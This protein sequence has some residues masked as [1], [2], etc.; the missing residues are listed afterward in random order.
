M[1]HQP[2]APSPFE[3]PSNPFQDPSITL[4]LNSG[5]RVVE[6]AETED[7]PLTDYNATSFHH[8]SDNRDPFGS[9]TTLENTKSYNNSAQVP[10][11]QNSEFN[12]REEALRQKEREL[13]D[14]ERNLEA[15]RQ[16]LGNKSRGG[17][18]NFPPCFPILYLNIVDEI[19]TQHQQTVMWL[20]R[21]WLL[22]LIT[23]GFNFFACLWVLFS[24]PPSITSAPTNM[25]VALTELFTHTLASFFLWYRP[26]YNAYMKDNSLY[27]CEYLGLEE[28][29]Q[30]WM[31]D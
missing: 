8:V 3:D 18:N 5:N 23:L 2:L 12:A 21:E 15:E 19:P 1:S 7:V 26:V 11:Q 14:R 13:A 4:A 17:L 16:R 25:G 22:F 28:G 29:L 6:E 10:Q 27:Y 31:D 20:Y 9:T 30:Q 24:H